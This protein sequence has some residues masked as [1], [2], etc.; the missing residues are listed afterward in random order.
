MSAILEKTTKSEPKAL[1]I[2]YDKDID[3]SKFLTK[4][5]AVIGFGSQGYGQ[6][7][8]LFE[9]KA[10]VK[11]ALRK[12]SKTAEKVKAAGLEVVHMEDVTEWADMIMFLC[13]DPQQGKI[14]K[15]H[16]EGKLRPGQALVFSHGFAIHYGEIVPPKDVDVFM[17]AP[18]GPGHTVRSEYQ[19][20]RGVP[21]LIAIH[22]DATGDAKDLALGYASCIGAGRGGIIET[23]FKD[24]TETDLFGEQA[25]LCGGT[26][27]LVKAG[28]ETLVEAG[29]PPE[30]AYFECLHELKLIVD[31]L[32]EGGLADMRYSISDTA[33]YG[34]ISRGSRIVT[35]ETK[36]AMKE[37]LSEIQSGKFAKEWMA[38]Y[39]AGMP[40]LKA[41]VEKDAQHQL[42]TTG[43]QLR[44]QMKWNTGSKLVNR[45]KN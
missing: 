12:E 33:R 21:A 37:I 22:Q 9:S 14:Y 36:K 7:V 42:E 11:I 41:T 16:F 27:A 3:T 4:K 6:S 43:K 2:Y 40:N 13:P 32:Y 8:N 30:M 1:K 38:E 28:F 45:D 19:R 24:E 29:Y 20:E 18:K 15:E 26:A 10:N 44:D 39:N 17:V 35:D 5:V 23:T 25:V 34:D 31:L